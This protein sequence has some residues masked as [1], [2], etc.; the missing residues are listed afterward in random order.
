[1]ASLSAPQ[2]LL[3][4]ILSKA[5][6]TG[7][8]WLKGVFLKCKSI[9]PDDKKHLRLDIIDSTGK[10]FSGIGFG[11]GHYILEIKKQRSFSVL[12]SLEEN[13]YNGAISLQL[14]IKSLKF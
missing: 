1:M 6:T 5:R 10:R 2:K 14:K 11:L 9:F 7:I 12:Y 13:R 8:F 4:Q 3:Y